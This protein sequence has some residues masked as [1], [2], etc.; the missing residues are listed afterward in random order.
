ML[1]WIREK[2]GT[3][4]IALIIGFIAFVFVFY[5]VFNP[6]STRGLHEGAVAGTVNGESISIGEFNRALNQR[7]EFFKSISGGNT[8]T[9]EQMKAFR[10]R[11]GVF[12]GLVRR[13][14]LVQEADRQGLNPSDEEVRQRI[15][16]ISA[17]HKNGKFDL[18]T[19]KQALEA[20]RY[21]PSGFERMVREDLSAQAWDQY[22][23]R[24]V[25]VSDLEIQKRF[26]LT[27]TKRN[28]KYALLT[29]ESGRKGIQV[30]A[31]EIK[32]YLADP[33][34]LNIAKGQFDRKQTT[35]F[36]GKT[37]EAVK[38]QIARDLLAS[39]KVEEIRKLNDALAEKLLQIGGTNTAAEAKMNSQLKPYGVELK[40]TGMITE[41]SGSLPGIGEATELLKDAFAK[42]SPIDPAQGGK[43]KKYTS[44][45]WT[46]VAWVTASQ[47]PEL[48]KLASERERLS[49]EIADAKERDLYEGWIKKVRE[50]AKI[51]MNPSVVSE[52]G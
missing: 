26:E 8:I 44:G 21:T 23:K 42:P 30:S 25:N 17:F 49:R 32:K 22:F 45:S 36:K 7:L 52:E 2:F 31:E 35:E 14:L 27:E 46:L 3:V 29:S 47:Q 11:E 18:L 9:E 6:K 51:D 43:P 15:Q 40:S 16:D 24:R 39:E 13:R 41:Q 33:A 50:R 28:I 5:G 38:D 48:S 4:I 1:T 37:F 10:V 34:K 12:E 19:Y 20:N